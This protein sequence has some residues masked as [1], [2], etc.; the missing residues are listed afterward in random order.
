[1][2]ITFGIKSLFA[3]FSV[4]LLLV[5]GCSTSGQTNTSE[6]V[7]IPYYVLAVFFFLVCVVGIPTA[8]YLGKRWIAVP[9]LRFLLVIF[10][11]LDPACDVEPIRTN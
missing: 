5:S 7:F 9:W 1:M 2:N 8:F 3:S 11:G 6:G 4:F 10:A